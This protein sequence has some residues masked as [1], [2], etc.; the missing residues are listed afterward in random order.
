MSFYDCFIPMSKVKYAVLSSFF[1]AI[2]IRVREVSIAKAFIV[3]PV[4][5]LVYFF[6]RPV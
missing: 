6:I 4:F 2:V 3:D 5:K 1:A